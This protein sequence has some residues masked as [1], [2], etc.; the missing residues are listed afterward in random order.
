MVADGRCTDVCLGL[1]GA[2]IWQEVIRKGKGM[3][4]SLCIIGVDYQGGSD[5][6]PG[7]VKFGTA[8]VPVFWGRCCPGFLGRCCPGFLGRCCPEGLGLL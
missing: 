3:Q 7:K 5:D 1:S 6:P 2:N 4:G 8:V